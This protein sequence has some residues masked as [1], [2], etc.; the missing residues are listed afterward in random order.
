L[1]ANTAHASK[2]SIFS[3]QEVHRA[4]KEMPTDKAPGPYGFTGIF[5]KVCWEI[6]K[7]DILL[8]FDSIYNLRCT[9]LNLL[10][11]ANIVLIPKKE[12]TE[13]VADYRPISLIHRIAKIFSKMLALRLRP[14]MH[15]L[16]SVNQ[17]AFIKRRSIHDNFL[18]VRNMARRY[19]R[20]RRAMLLFKLD[21]TKAFDSVRWDYLLALLQRRGFPTRWTD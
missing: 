12:G 4:I 2:C 8:V 21:I 13:G 15:L 20:L 16:I 6:I 17:S 1:E 10:N 3:E 9:H 14:H 7:E 5:F 18:F 11:S 19:H